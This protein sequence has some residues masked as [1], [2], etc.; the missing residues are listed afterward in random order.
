[1]AEVLT[2]GESTGYEVARSIGWTRRQRK[3]AEL[4]LMNQMLAICETVY[5]LDLLVTQC[6]A[7]S[8]TGPD[9]VRRYQPAQP[10]QPAAALAHDEEV[11]S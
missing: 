11:T 7:V 5:H 3:L 9:G 1:M 10:A 4:D 8:S 6:R 2:G